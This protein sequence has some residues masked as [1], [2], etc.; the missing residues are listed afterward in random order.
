[1]QGHRGTVVNAAAPAPAPMGPTPN[2]L[3]NWG[4]GRGGALLFTM[5]DRA[6]ICP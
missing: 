2:F 4:V 5:A 3:L 6:P 1:M